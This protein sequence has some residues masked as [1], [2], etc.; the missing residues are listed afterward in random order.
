MLFM[1]LHTGLQGT[2]SAWASYDLKDCVVLGPNKGNGCFISGHPSKAA[3]SLQLN[4]CVSAS[5]LT[6]MYDCY[7]E[8]QW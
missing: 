5:S 7:I 8:S 1:Q 4:Q 3:A 6:C 2:R